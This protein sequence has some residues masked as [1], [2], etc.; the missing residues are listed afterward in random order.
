MYLILNLSLTLCCFSHISFRSLVCSVPFFHNM[1][2]WFCSPLL[3]ACDDHPV[4]MTIASTCCHS[5][6][7]FLSYTVR[8]IVCSVVIPFLIAMWFL[9][10]AFGRLNLT[11]IQ[12]TWFP[13]LA[14]TVHFFLHPSYTLLVF[15]LIYIASVASKSALSCS[16]YL[17]RFCSR[18]AIRMQWLGM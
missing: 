16:S 5:R 17:D 1:I 6:V 13:V 4:S 11:I 3:S 2:S 7:L 8:S 15:S 14:G 9:L 12:V 10:F 18:M